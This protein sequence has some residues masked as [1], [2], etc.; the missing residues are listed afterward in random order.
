MFTIDKRK[1]GDFLLEYN[2]TMM[3]ATEYKEKGL[4]NY[5]YFFQHDGKRLW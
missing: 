2:G 4:G 1:K 3:K 5:L